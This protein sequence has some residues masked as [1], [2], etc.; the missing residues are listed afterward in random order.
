MLVFSWVCYD[1]VWIC[2]ILY[3]RWVWLKEEKNPPSHHVTNLC[4]GRS[5]SDVVFLPYKQDKHMKLE[6]FLLEF[7]RVYYSVQGDA[8]KITHF[9]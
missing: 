8:T 7:L 9:G 2:S 3:R 5:T 6:M 1:L 4:Q